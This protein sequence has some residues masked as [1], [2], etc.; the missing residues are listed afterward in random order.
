LSLKR[1]EFCVMG[2]LPPFQG[3]RIFL[4]LFQIMPSVAC[5]IIYSMEKILVSLILI[6]CSQ[7]KL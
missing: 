5:L 3:V 7:L 1:A 6:R 4:G 2:R